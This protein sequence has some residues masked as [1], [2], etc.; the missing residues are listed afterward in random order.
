MRINGMHFHR[1]DNSVD[2]YTTRQLWK[3]VYNFLLG[4]GNLAVEDFTFYNLDASDVVENQTLVLDW[5]TMNVLS[6]QFRVSI[7]IGANSLNVK[8]HN[9][10]ESWFC[11]KTDADFYID[12][13]TNETDKT[14]VVLEA[15][16]RY[17]IDYFENHITVEKYND[18]SIVSDDNEEEPGT[19]EDEPIELPDDPGVLYVYKSGDTEFSNC[20]Y[21]QMSKNTEETFPPFDEKGLFGSVTGTI[22]DC[23]QFFYKSSSNSPSSLS[24]VD[25]VLNTTFANYSKLYIE[26]SRYFIVSYVGS[27]TKVGFVNEDEDTS[28]GLIYDGGS[29]LEEIS[30]N[31]KVYE[32]DISGLEVSKKIRFQLA[33]VYLR[34]YNI[35]LE[36]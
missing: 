30:T 8:F 9:E 7:K 1:K 33:G 29:V 10:K 11:L 35:W 20:T 16:S 28:G 5:T 19:D 12:P 6:G 27:G 31:R 25:L 14:T 22:T 17:L 34:I 2:G 23:V 15:N 18:P 3:G 4:G 13:E 21:G 32:F 36:P 26:A 24:Y